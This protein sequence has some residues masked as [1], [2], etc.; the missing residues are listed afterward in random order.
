MCVHVCVS[1]REVL[2]LTAVSWYGGRKLD[3]L[4]VAGDDAG[5]VNNRSSQEGIY[6]LF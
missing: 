3:F 6:D 2:L 1:V 4:E 5:V